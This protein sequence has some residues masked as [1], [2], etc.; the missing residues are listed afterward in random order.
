MWGPAKGSTSSLSA[1]DILNILESHLYLTELDWVEPWDTDAW[2]L[3]TSEKH[4]ALQGR[5]FLSPSG[6]FSLRE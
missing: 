5:G 1:T 6:I 2:L 4:V 3:G